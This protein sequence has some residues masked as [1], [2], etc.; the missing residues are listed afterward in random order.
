MV[1]T[2]KTN[3]TC[4]GPMCRFFSDGDGDGDFDF[5][6]DFERPGQ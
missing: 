3:S 5:D 2:E 6:F 4:G 1:V